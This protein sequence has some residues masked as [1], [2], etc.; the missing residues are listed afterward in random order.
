MAFSIVADTP[1]AP[2]SLTGITKSSR[3]SCDI[4]TGTTE[5]LIAA[6]LI[7]PGQLNPQKGRKPG[8]TA[9]LASGEPCP[10]H[11]RAWREPG[12][13]AIRQQDD[14]SY[15]VEVT[16]AKDVQLWRRRAEK[17]A[18]HEAEQ[19]RIDKELAENGH[20]YRNWA[21]E[22]DFSG[23][24]ESWAGTKAQFQAAGLGVGL[25]FPGE[26]GAPEKVRCKCPL[27]FEFV[28]RLPDYDRAKREARIYTAH[29]WYYP[30][31]E[32]S[33]QFEAHSPGVL[34]KVWTPDGYD[35]S[36]DTFEGT[37]D[38]LVAA[39]LVPDVRYFPGRPGVNKTQATYL[40]DWRPAS[41]ANGQDWGAT[42]RKRGNS[43]RFS[44]E[45]SVSKQEFERR[46]A[47]SKARDEERQQNE[48][49]LSA[50]RQQ[51]RQAAAPETSA[52]DFRAE[53]A[54]RAE[55]S[56]NFLWSD[57]F[58]RDD[59]A[60]SFDIPKES[61]LRDNLAEAF[62][63]IRDAV[64]EADIL[65]DKKQVAAAR[66]RLKLVAARNDKGLQSLLQNAQH[67]RLVQPTSKD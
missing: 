10:I 4:Y 22:Q 9:F 1:A 36:S 50:E 19:E 21:F 62:Q 27:G 7:T 24:A 8:Y 46:K 17:A 32:E 30:R 42:I 49:R 47:L 35:A 67:L 18:Q 54:R 3:W 60:L 15:C 13:K 6:G 29:S 16:A 28:I 43:G 44:M 66:T 34:R 37:A 56:L 11:L 12:F 53:R 45:I 61:E 52:D 33:K 26:P 58:G 20:K 14:G 5:A 41:T 23:C 64:Q 25:T 59:G 51:L 38:A 31:R 57:V 55:F 40:K 63:T 65:Q 48:L 2:F 39:G